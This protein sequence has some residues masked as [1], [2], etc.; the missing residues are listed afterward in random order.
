MNGMVPQ[1]AA[2]EFLRPPNASSVGGHYPP[3]SQDDDNPLKRIEAMTKLCDPT[4][5]NN[6]VNGNKMSRIASNMD[7]PDAE[8]AAAQSKEEKLAKLEAINK[9]MSTTPNFCNQ[10][11]NP[12]MRRPQ[13]FLPAGMNPG[14]G[15]LM[16]SNQPQF[17]PQLAAMIHHQRQQQAAFYGGPQPNGMAWSG[18]GPPGGPQMVMG[19]NGPMPASH[20][21]SFNPLNQPNG[22]MMMA[23]GMPNPQ[24]SQF[25]GGQGM[26][27]GPGGQMFSPAQMAA[28]QQHH[29]RMAQPN[30]QNFQPDMRPGPES[31]YWPGQQ[32]MPQ[33]LANLDSRVPVQKMQYFPNSQMGQPQQSMA[34][35]VPQ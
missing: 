5:N 8:A 20:S 21:P 6:A 2:S 19:P 27:G 14:P 3:P 23:G 11:N 22:Q 32:H 30:Q 28:M 33:P 29:M 10:T 24:Q 9:F 31:N 1:S 15:N 16:P 4:P 18:G 25:P 7:M 17:D 35:G 12:G 34:G 26:P 13:F